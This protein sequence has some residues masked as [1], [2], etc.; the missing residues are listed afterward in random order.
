[1]KTCNV[2]NEEKPLSEFYTNAGMR[3]GY[4]NRCKNCT[5]SASTERA[6][7]MSKDAE[8][9][10][11]EAER[12][13]AKARRYRAEGRANP[14][15]LEKRRETLRRHRLKYP[16]RARAREAVA[17]AI[18][19]KKLIPKPCEKCG[20]KAQA[21]HDDYTKPLAVRWLCPAHH[22]EAHVAAR[23]Y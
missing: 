12:H 20:R 17:R 2:C 18:R 21:H 10:A 3:D 11:A 5:K 4:Q 16:E 9:R 23:T 13:R 8:W 19:T 15:P 7:R 14:V 22:A 1:M 6:L